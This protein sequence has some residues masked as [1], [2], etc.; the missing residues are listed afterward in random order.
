M[1]TPP[2]GS[3]AEEAAKLF[4]AAE[5]WARSRAGG[6]LDQDH[7]ATGSAECSVCPVC[8]TVQAL[9]QVTPETVDHLLDAAASVVAALRSTVIGTPPDGDTAARPTVQHIDV[10]EG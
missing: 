10:G 8:Q 4:A 5:Q 6:L 1:T 3:A 9:R 7:L 2:L